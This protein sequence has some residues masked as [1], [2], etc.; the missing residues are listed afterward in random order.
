MNDLNTLGLLFE[1]L[2]VRDLR[3]YADALDGKIHHYRDKNGLECDAVLHL[4]DGRYG[5]IEIKLGGDRLVSEG[6]S[7]ILKL[8]S[9][10]DTDKMNEPSFLMVLTGVGAYAYQ[11]LEGVW[12]VPI[13]CLKD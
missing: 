11:T 8:A 4:R 5:L 1:T 9:K 10:I 7:N 12:V 2:C 3:V 13:S 6:I